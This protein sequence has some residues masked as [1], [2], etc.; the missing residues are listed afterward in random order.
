MPKN[1]RYPQVD[2]DVLLFVNDTHSKG[3][4]LSRQM[5]QLKVSEAEYQ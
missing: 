3:L 1:G 4:P 2:E 5:M